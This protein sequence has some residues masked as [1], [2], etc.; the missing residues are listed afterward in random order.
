MHKTLGSPIRYSSVSRGN[1]KALPQTLLKRKSQM[2]LGLIR[3]GEYKN[4][5]YAKFSVYF[6]CPLNNDMIG[7][8]FIQVKGPSV[9]CLKQKKRN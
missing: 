7:Y 5:R 1:T 3:I 6:F 9:D 8:E 2:P 4:P